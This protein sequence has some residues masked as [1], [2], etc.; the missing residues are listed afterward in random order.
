MEVVNADVLKTDLAALIEE[1]F[2]GMPVYVCA[3]LPYYITSPVVMY[4]LQSRLPVE[5]ITVMVQKEAAERLCANVGQR[6]SGAVTVAVNYYAQAERLLISSMISRL[7]ALP[8]AT[9]SP[10]ISSPSPSISEKDST[11]LATGTQAM[12]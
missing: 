8:L 2:A 11:T 3:N 10:S 1:R 6:E 5:N 7:P 9:A 4:L 12:M